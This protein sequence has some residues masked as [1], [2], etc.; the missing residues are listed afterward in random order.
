METYKIF[1][2][3]KL[4]NKY[5]EN[6]LVEQTVIQ[7]LQE[8]WNDS[9]CHINAYSDTEDA[10][11]GRAHRG[12]V[13]LV[14]YLKPA[15][16]RLNRSVD[17]AAIDRAIEEIVKSRAHMQLVQ[18]NREVYNL[19]RDGVPIS[20]RTATGEMD[21]EYIKIF[22]FE[23]PENN[24]FLLVSQLWIKGAVYTTRPDLIVFV[25]GIP[26]LNQLFSNR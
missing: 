14:K 19:L 16:E 21:T 17:G 22:D 2:I 8:L 9:A 12:E 5:N 6:N 1:S 7:I 4:M 24:S 15:M 11:L 18:A 25:N 3:N 20:V 26:L 10:R 23:N 13:V